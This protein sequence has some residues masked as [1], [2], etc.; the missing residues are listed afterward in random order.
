MN[1]QK[2]QQQ[3]LVRSE[4]MAEPTS[5]L[6]VISRAASDPNVDVD[7]MERLFAMQ[8]RFA[9]K[10]A[11][12]EFNG[13]MN[14]AQSKIGRV[15]ANRENDQT[16]SRYPD[17]AAL[18]RVCRPVYTEEGFSVSYG[19]EDSPKPE[20]VRVVAL[21]SHS[22][23]HTR[24]YHVDMPADGK[25]A[26]GGDVMTKTHATGAATA[27]GM[28]YLLKMIWNIAIGDDDTDGNPVGDTITEEQVADLEALMTEVG[29]NRA[30][31]LRFCKVSSVDQIRSK[32]YKAAV[33][34]LEARRS[35]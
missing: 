11:E 34:A 15:A 23:G 12:T 10:Q 21:V 4:P 22:A 7:K 20:H 32:N 24:T 30:M 19:T 25:G 26:K 28:R 35:K 13:A 27:Y 16:K 31:F 29:A 33:A 1:E 5:I 3:D 8:E 9:A 18:D 2:Q 14:R 6:A 17:Y